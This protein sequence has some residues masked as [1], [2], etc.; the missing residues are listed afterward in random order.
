VIGAGYIQGIFIFKDR[1]KIFDYNIVGISDFDHVTSKICSIYGTTIPVENDI[2]NIIDHDYPIQAGIRENIVIGNEFYIGVAVY[3]HVICYG[4]V[5][6]GKD[7][8]R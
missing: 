8:D 1:I 5:G 6:L 2:M 4:D 3:V 7:N